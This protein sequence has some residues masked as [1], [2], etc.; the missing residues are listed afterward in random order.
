MKIYTSAE[1]CFHKGFYNLQLAQENSLSEHH[2]FWLIHIS[3]KLTLSLLKM[4]LPLLPSS[5]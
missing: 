3:L 4:R 1:R 5:Q 2:A